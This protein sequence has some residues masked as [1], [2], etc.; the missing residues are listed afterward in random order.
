MFRR[1]QSRAD[2]LSAKEAQ[3]KELEAAA[4][5]ASEEHSQTD[6]DRP[7]GDDAAVD[8]DGFDIDVEGTLHDLDVWGDGDFDDQI[9]LGVARR[10][11]V[12]LVLKMLMKLR[13]AAQTHQQM[14]PFSKGGAV[15]KLFTEVVERCAHTPR[16]PHL[17]CAPR[18][19]AKGIRCWPWFHSH[20]Q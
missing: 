4:R 8:D 19:S 15:K 17:A 18:S 1:E 2:A 6:F 14:R 13:L 16:L 3:A 7:A 11:V 10:D 9:L 20:A 5:E 12:N